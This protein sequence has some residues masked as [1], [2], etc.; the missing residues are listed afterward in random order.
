V[1]DEIKLLPSGR[2][3]VVDDNVV[4]NPKYSKNLFEK[5]IPLQVKWGGQASITLAHDDNHLKLLKKSGCEWLFI[6]IESLSAMNLADMNKKINKI[7]TLEENIKKIKRAGIKI[8]GS[9][10]FGF[11]NDDLSTFE[12]V[13]DF[14]IRNRLDASNFYILTPLPGTALN[15]QMKEEGRILSEDWDLYDG[16]HVIFQPKNMSPEELLEG[17]IWAYNKMYSLNSIFRRVSGLSLG[18]LQML[19]LNLLRMKNRK[20]FGEWSRSV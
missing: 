7:E 14:C 13:V 3:I 12:K 10:I 15:T 8:I 19:G 5:M 17:Y 1:I 20:K 9:F 6:G 16:N 18:N 4:G 2:F 11:D